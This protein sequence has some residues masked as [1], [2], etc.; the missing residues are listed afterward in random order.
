VH[1][2]IVWSAQLDV[3]Q[4]PA[5]ELLLWHE[6]NCVVL[7]CLGM[8]ASARLASPICV[9]CCSSTYASACHLPLLSRCWLLLLA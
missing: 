8:C 4:L 6:V 9:A 7:E 2:L 1:Q 3:K 5:E